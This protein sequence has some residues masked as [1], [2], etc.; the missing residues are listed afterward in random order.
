M[1]SYIVIIEYVTTCVEDTEN[2]PG[3]PAYYAAIHNALNG[4]Q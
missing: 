3:N 1:L 2:M 4:E